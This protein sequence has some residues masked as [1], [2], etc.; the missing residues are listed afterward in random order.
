MV[1]QNLARKDNM[2]EKRA[3]STRRAGG[4]TSSKLQAS[5]LKKATIKK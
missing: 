2:K 3:P 5:S 4:P 1:S